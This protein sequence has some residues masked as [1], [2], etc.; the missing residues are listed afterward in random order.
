MAVGFVTRVVD[1]L[2]RFIARKGQER[3]GDNLTIYHDER[4]NF[5]WERI[6]KNKKQ[7]VKRFVNG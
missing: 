5:L 6:M 1:G 2:I 7:K 3:G 4:G